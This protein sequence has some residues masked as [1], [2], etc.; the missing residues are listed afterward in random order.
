MN[1]KTEVLQAAVLNHC[2]AIQCTCKEGQMLNVFPEFR[3]PVVLPQGGINVGLSDL[4]GKTFAWSRSVQRVS[5]KEAIHWYIASKQQ[6]QT[7]SWR[8]AY[9]KD[10]SWNIRNCF[11]R[12]E[13]H[14]MVLISRNVGPLRHL[15]LRSLGIKEYLEGTL[16]AEK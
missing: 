16:D 9:H 6:Q 4:A 10:Q 7:F 13:W 14:D 12:R 11:P 2:A 8:S 5:C 3:Y 15:G 1:S